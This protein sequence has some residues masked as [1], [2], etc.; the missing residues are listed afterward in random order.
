MIIDMRVY[1]YVPSR[2]ATFM[3]LYGEA[4]FAL[5]TKHLGRTAGIFTSHAGVANRTLQLFA[6]RDADHRDACRDSLR[7][8][9]EWHAFIRE[10]GQHIVR[11]TNTIIRPTAFSQLREFNQLADADA[12]A[13][14]PGGN[15]MMFELRTYTAHPGK[16]GEALQ[17]LAEEGCPL[18]HQYVQ[19]PVGYFTAETG[20]SNRVFMLWGYANDGERDRRREAM[21][22]DAAFLELGNR[23]NPLF[24]HQ[25]GDLWN[26][27]A[28]SPLR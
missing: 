19:R 6:Y 24:Q 7:G 5:T 11:Q 1:E 10:A 27:T 13:E 3:K 18:T 21:R 25:E 16:L 28:Y 9:P 15:P 23:F 17:L 12:W 20:V 4:G 14:A 2:F 26:A 8:D 22:S